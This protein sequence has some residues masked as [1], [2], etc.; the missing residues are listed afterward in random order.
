LSLPA[1]KQRRSL[2]GEILDWMLAPLFLLWPMSVAI[3]YV[4]AI[5]LSDAPHD[6]SLT[7]ALAVLSD[8][9]KTQANG[10]HSVNLSSTAQLALR[11]DSE[12]GIFWKMID[13][14]NKFIAGD[15]V[16]PTP[17][18]INFDDPDPVVHFSDYTSGGFRLRLAYKWFMPTELNP[19]TLNPSALNPNT[20]NL[21]ASSRTNSNLS[22]SNS[23][24]QPVFIIVAEGIESR[25]ALANDIIKGVIIPQFLVLPVAALLIWF[26]LS[27]GVA[28][29][30]ALQKRLRAR[31][32]DDLSEIDVQST[33][34]EITPL[35]SAMNDLLVR[36]SRNIQTQR[37]FVA[38]AAHQ[39]KTPLAGLRMQAEL[40][41]KSAPNED[42]VL[43]LKQI[44][45]G[46]ENAT[47]LINQ[48]LLLATAEKRDQIKLETVDLQALA[49]ATTLQ[50]V[51]QALAQHIDLGF[52]GN[53]E[54]PIQIMG[55]PVLVAE[56]L[57]NLVDNAL[58]YVGV[59]GHVTVSV[60]CTSRHALLT[61]EDNGPGIPSAERERVFDRFYR[62][63]GT[64]TQGS[65]LGLAIVKEI[66]QRHQADIT[67]E[68]A[69][70]NQASPGMKIVIRFPLI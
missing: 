11:T 69:Q 7:T 59:S 19:N 67:I 20:L 27:R 4:V 13:P 36:L 22:M 41:L 17:A 15:P 64:G 65:G 30:N 25:T 58:S 5:N 33:P 26:G 40:A 34:S 28:P 60:N 38:D 1:V 39:L 12:S 43:N 47:R 70:A 45:R 21:N 35:V 9:I 44:V 54:Q 46:T 63:L 56:L 3:T 32:P 18:N 62:V 61:V 23:K 55:Q 50:W 8:Q 68:D 57:N 51:P 37:R 53:N 42:I 31:R 24:H 48:L 49:E 16:V 52:E 6:Q 2:L 29:I 10:D 66:A 14:Q